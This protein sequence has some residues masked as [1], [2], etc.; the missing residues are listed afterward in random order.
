MELGGLS[1]DNDNDNDDE[2]EEDEE[3]EEVEARPCRGVIYRGTRKESYGREVTRM[4]GDIPYSERPL[5]F[6]EKC[7]PP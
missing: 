6:N 2:D 7:Q 4:P 3:D 5:A 1:N